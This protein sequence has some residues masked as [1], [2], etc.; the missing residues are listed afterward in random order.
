[1]NFKDLML[2][3]SLAMLTTWG[4]HYF[5]FSGNASQQDDQ[6]RSGQSFI[7]PKTKQESKPLNAEIVFSDT[8]ESKPAQLSHV[9]TDGAVL[10]FSTDGAS[11]ERLEFKHLGSCLAC[12]M[13][14]I[15][16][17][18]QTER[19]NRAFLV[20]LGNNT[21]YYYDLM[22]REDKPDSVELTYRAEFKDGVIEKKYTVYAHT[23]KID[24][25]IKLD[26]KN[27]LKI[28]VEPRV[29][30]TSPM[31]ASLDQVDSVAAIF[32]NEKGA[33]EKVSRGDVKLDRGWF[34]PRFF[35]SEDKYFVH[36]LIED[37]QGFAQRAYYK[38]ADK[39]KLISILEGPTVGQ[40]AASCCNKWQ[41][42]FYFGPKE[43]AAFDAV[44]PRLEQTLEYSG[45][46]SPISKFLLRILNWLYSYIKNYG[47]AIIALTVLVKLVLLPFTYNAEA[48]MQKKTDF[49]KK[50]KY[51]QQKYKNDP[52]MLAHERGELIKKHGM[53]GLSGCLP[54]LLQLPIFFALSRVL[55]SALELYH[56]PFYGWIHDLSAHDPYYVLPLVTAAG[57]IL[58]STAVPNNDPKQ[59]MSAVVMALVIGAVTAKLAAGLALYICAFSLLGIIQTKAL[60]VFKRS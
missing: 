58:Q 41:L 35:G 37:K 21:P 20:A 36:A 33:I 28:A 12:P 44:D 11:L 6:V 51:V 26:I 18:T 42:S 10:V 49:D 3:L 34:A 9:E 14:T 59:K 2:P 48:G 4:V 25:D 60:K 32:N 30:F 47:L 27:P 17:P 8:K 29:F 13:K 19:E 55:S 15:E 22:S 53:P 16:A 39:N 24:L 46:L 1:M 5:F 31:V 38:F 52:E 23:Y 45:L 50:L 7:A 57:M 54:L 56:A 40:D 43:V